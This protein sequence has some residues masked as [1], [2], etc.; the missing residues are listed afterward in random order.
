MKILV[1]IMPYA[2]GVN[3]QA[4]STD[5]FNYYL[6]LKELAD[7]VVLFDYYKLH[8]KHGKIKMN[9]YLLSQVK[10]LSPDFLFVILHTDEFIPRVMD[11]IK[12]ITISLGFF[13]DDIWRQDYA[14]FWSRYFSYVLSTDPDGEKKFR[15]MGITNVLSFPQAC[16]QNVYTYMQRAKEYEVTFVGG[17]H[18][19]RSWLVNHLR[20]CGID[21]KVFGAGWSRDKFIPSLIYKVTNRLHRARLS[22]NQICEVLPSQEEMIE[23]FNRSK[24]NLNLSNATNWDARYL[25]SSPLALINT[26][27]SNKYRDGIKLRL[28]EISA[29]RGFQLSYYEEG[30]EKY[31]KIGEEIAIFLNPDNLADKVK[32][33]LKHDKERE[34]IARSGYERTLREHTVTKRFQN[35]FER[36]KINKN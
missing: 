14:K 30:L 34:L 26:F 23:I 4:F 17:Y 20:R 1:A 2:Y 12:K 15:A 31:F 6:G 8:R 22:I 5:Y 7:E 21:V 3:D 16:N 13:H 9:E 19:H 33:Y 25:S 11:E 35:I 27:R 32:Y 24:I 36:C 28:F 18:P 29:C 10:E